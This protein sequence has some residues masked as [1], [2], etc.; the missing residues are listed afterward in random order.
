M[1]VANDSSL[2]VGD[3]FSIEAWVKR[4]SIGGSANQVIA[5]KQA[6][7][8]VLMFNTSNQLVL[9]K[10]TVADA[11]VSTATITDTTSWHY[12]AATKDGGSLKLYI[13]GT[14]VTGT[15]TNQTMTDN[16]LPLAIGQSSATAFF[17]GVIDEVALY[18]IA[19]TPTQISNRAGIPPV[20]TS[21]PTV[22]GGAAVGQVLSGGSGTWSGTQPVSH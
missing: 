20:N 12:V 8:W 13:D 5:S 6:N 18:S 16:T 14:D 4:G 7:S 1:Q 22:S 19:L 9:R 21:F 15:I 11:V 17:N 3:R 10:S 2:N